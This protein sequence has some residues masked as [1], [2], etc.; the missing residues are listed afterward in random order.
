V[1]IF[2]RIQLYTC[3]IWYCHSQWEFL[4]ACRYT[5]WVRTHDSILIT[6]LMHW[7][8]FIHKILIS[9]T[10]FE[11]QVLIFRRTQFYKCSIW[12][13]HSLWEFLVACRYTAWVR[14][15]DYIL[16]TNLMHWLLFIH[17]IL[18]FS[19]CFEPQVLIFRR[20]QLYTCSI[21]Y[22]HSLWEFL[23]AVFTQAVY[24]QATRNSHREWQYHI[25]HVYNCILLKMSTWGSKHVEENIILWI[26]NNQCIK[27]VINI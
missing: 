16:I 14:T 22:C 27:L 12:Y 1:L 15:H 9:A 10:C 2:R 23:V 8:L 6:N 21:W 5:A 26:N 25:L 17:K 3:S 20:I 13:C 4:V 18:S 24:R 7:L 19:T 11:P